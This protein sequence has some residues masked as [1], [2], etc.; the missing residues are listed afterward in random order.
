[1]LG[2]K[3]RLGSLLNFNI[4]VPK[5]SQMNID[6]MNFNNEDNDSCASIEEK[7]DMKNQI[8][9][10]AKLPHSSFKI[11][12]NPSCFFESMKKPQ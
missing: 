6:E 10:M 8:E 4:S 9:E 1:M 11:F 2:T 12:I 3:Q 5:I 7:I